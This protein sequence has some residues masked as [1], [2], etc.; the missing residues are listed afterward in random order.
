MRKQNK[1]ALTFGFCLLCCVKLL[2]AVAQEESFDAQNRR[3]N[4]SPMIQGQERANMAT[5]LASLPSKA[6]EN[7]ILYAQDGNTYVNKPELRAQDWPLVQVQDNVYQD[8]AGNCFNAP[9]FNPKPIENIASSE[10][11][12]NDTLPLLESRRPWVWNPAQTPGSGPY[13]RVYSKVPPDDNTP[14]FSYEDAYVSLPNRFGKRIGPD[15]MR[16]TGH[17]KYG[18]IQVYEN[19]LTQDT[20]YVYMG[21]WSANAKFIP[22][23]PTS[24]NPIRTTT[25]AVDAGFYHDKKRYGRNRDSWIMFIG[26]EASVY[27]I[28]VDH[29]RE[30]AGTFRIV[31]D[32]QPFFVAFF[33][34]YGT[35]NLG[36][37]TYL[38]LIAKADAIDQATGNDLGVNTWTMAK[39]VTQ[40]ESDLGKIVDA[41]GNLFCPWNINGNGM[42]LKRMTSI[43]QQGAGGKQDNPITCSYV[44][45]AQWSNCRLAVSANT[46]TQAPWGANYGGA[47]NYAFQ[48]NIPNVVRVV[49]VDTSNE[50]D[51]IVIP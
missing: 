28:E 27:G 20:A 25:F 34:S 49:Q 12:L 36:G 8:K 14:G 29:V 24:T 15:P 10:A 50:T 4:I 47:L 11:P 2:P 40:P 6:R 13:R 17:F 42:V 31:S 35:D 41:S 1:S 30:R 33:V 39:E 32:Q 48:A 46:G 19:P 7:V 37:H 9:P 51:S 38:N 16:G 45:N 18:P 5:L 44:L 23:T 21:G 26:A 43:A 22:A 3:L